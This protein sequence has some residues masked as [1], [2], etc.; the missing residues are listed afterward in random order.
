MSE[1]GLGHE[2]LKMCVN[3]TNLL[4]EKRAMHCG[5]WTLFCVENYE[6]SVIEST[7]YV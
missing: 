4:C 3:L 2:T 6:V 5:C 7:S 1:I